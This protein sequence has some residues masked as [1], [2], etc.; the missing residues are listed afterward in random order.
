MQLVPAFLS[1]WAWTN[2]GETAEERAA[3]FRAY[4]NRDRL[5]MA[6]IAYVGTQAM[7]IAGLREHDLPGREDLSPWLAT[8][9]VRPEFRGN[10]VASALCRHAEERARQLGIRQIYLFTVDK[11]GLYTRL[12]WR[13]HDTGRWMDHP[14][15]IMT[16]TLTERD[17]FP[18]R[19]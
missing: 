3:K 16:K 10:G 2:R 9:F 14:V 11:Q 13:P 4:E 15:E 12:G 5:P 19:A 1:E 8:V 7:G 6:W 18:S 17:R